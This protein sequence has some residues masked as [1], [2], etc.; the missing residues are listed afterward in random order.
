MKGKTAAFEICDQL[1]SAPDVLAI[2]VGNAGNITAYWKG[3][4]EYEKEKGY[5]KPR[6]HGFE[7]GAAAIVKGHVIEEPETIATAIRIGN[8]ASWSYAVEAAKQS[9][10]EIDMV[11]DEEILHAYRLLAKQKAFLLSQIKCFISGC[12]E[13][14]SIWKNQKGRNSCCSFNWKRFERS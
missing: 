6:I 8:P 14:C 11:S 4:C 3:F 13:T 7:A 9:H 1:Q 10:G 12:N 5:K 2:P